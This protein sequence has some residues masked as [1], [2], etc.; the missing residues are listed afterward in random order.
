MITRS[1]YVPGSLS[2]ALTQRYRGLGLSF[3]RK[4]HFIPVGNPAPPR[5]RRFDFLTSAMMSSGAIFSQP[6]SFA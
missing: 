6:P 3:G 5:P 2:S 1:L 4:P